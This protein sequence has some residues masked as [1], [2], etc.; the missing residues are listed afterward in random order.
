LIFAD[1]HQKVEKL[2]AKVADIPIEGRKTELLEKDVS[3]TFGSDKVNSLALCVFLK[4]LFCFLTYCEI[5]FI[6]IFI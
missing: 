3:K 4:K 5:F 2:Q 1:I 6:Y